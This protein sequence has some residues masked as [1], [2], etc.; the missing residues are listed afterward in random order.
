M[1]TQDT[2]NAGQAPGNQTVT[3]PQEPAPAPDPVAELQRKVEQLEKQ[4]ADKDKYIGEIKSE[5]ETLESRLSQRTVPSNTPDDVSGLVKS[6]AE[7]ISYDPEAATGEIISF[8]K[9]SQEQVMASMRPVIEETMYIEQQKSANKEV[10]EFFGEDYL[11]VKGAQLIQSGRAKNAR[12]AVDTVISEA[13]AKMSKI[14]QPSQPKPIPTQAQGEEGGN[15]PPETPP[16]PAPENQETELAARL[17]KRRA[18]G[19]R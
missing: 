11:Y 10:I 9:K 4:N 7:K 2:P 8:V 3:P 14:T 5:K 18:Q 15:K 17:A 1:G 16:P 6:V 13:K 19:L 12:E